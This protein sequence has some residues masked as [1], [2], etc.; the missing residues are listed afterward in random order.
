MVYG[1]DK[2][3]S[4]LCKNCLVVTL[5]CLKLVVVY[6]VYYDKLFKLSNLVCNRRCNLGGHTGVVN[7][8]IVLCKILI[9]YRTNTDL[10]DVYLGVKVLSK[11]LLNSRD[12]L[13]LE[14]LVEINVKDAEG[15]NSLVQT[16]YV[17]FVIT[18]N[19]DITRNGNVC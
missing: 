18:A 5:L 17:G 9:N 12:V 11:L 15:C 14:K 7:R 6:A 19:D 16:L 3:L 1:I 10:V 13:L 2:V 8:D 4:I